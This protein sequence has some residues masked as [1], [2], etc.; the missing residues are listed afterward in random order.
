MTGGLLIQVAYF[1][2]WKL[3]TNGIIHE[4]IENGLNGEND[5]EFG[6]SNM[7]LTVRQN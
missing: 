6:W 7:G 3:L 1:L 2:E 4:I 5:H